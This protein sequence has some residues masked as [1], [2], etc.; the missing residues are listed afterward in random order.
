MKILVTGCNG[1]LGHDC[2]GRFGAR[3]TVK[4]LDLPEFDITRA[5]S[6]RAETDA[7]LPDVIVN[8]AA[9]TNVDAAETDRG[10]AWAVN[11]EAP[12]YLA[13]CAERCSVRLIHVSTDYV[14]DGALP[15]PSAYSETDTPH[16]CTVYGQS[17]LAGEKAVQGAFSPGHD[18]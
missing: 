16:P 14:F 2:L 11:A 6:V 12:R 7:F 9:Y 4:G 8:C 3:H 18:A 5:E 10:S 17:K 15:R 1:Q 13:E